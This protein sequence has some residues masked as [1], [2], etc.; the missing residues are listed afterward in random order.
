MM[1]TSLFKT[2]AA[3]TFLLLSS[4]AFSQTETQYVDYINNSISKFYDSVNIWW[5]SPASIPDSLR[6]LS[7]PSYP[8]IVYQ[9]RIENLDELT[10]IKLEYNDVVLKYIKAYGISNRPKMESVIALS[11]YYFPIFEE[12]LAKYGLPLELKYL[13]AVESSLDP[14]AISKSGAVGLWQ[15][16]KPTAD[17]M[18]LKVSTY[19]DERRDVRK[20]T[21]AACRYLR[22]LYETFR[23]WQLALVAYNGGQGTVKNAIER[24]GGK[25]NHWELLPF[26][27]DQMKNYVGAFIAMEYLLQYHAEHNI[28]P[29]KSVIEYMKTDTLHVKGP[30]HLKNIAQSIE[31]DYETVKFLNPTFTQAYIPNDGEYH[32]LTL[33]FDKTNVFI[34]HQSEISSVP[35]QVN[36]SII[37]SEELVSNIKRDNLITHT[38]IAGDNLFRISM[39]YKCSIDEIKKW[40]DMEEN[41]V[42]HVGDKIKIYTE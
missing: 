2:L 5:K 34:A 42:I 23:D 25:T 22:Y 21:D 6:R 26:F 9:K 3:A 36:D 35:T 37:A 33:P 39:K 16:L 30:L 14:N 15:F 38:V 18:G 32:V 41:H 17:V 11:A 40:N 12:Y 24:S 20:S 1:K 8:E 19:I 29:K 4:V 7:A 13:A 28:F 10:T 31:V 27:T